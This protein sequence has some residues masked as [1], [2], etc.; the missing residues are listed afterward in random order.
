MTKHNM[1][2]SE[3]KEKSTLYIMT[4]HN[5]QFSENKEKST[6]YIMTK[7]NMQFS[8]NKEKSTLYIMTKHNMQFSENKEKSKL[9]IMTKQHAIFRRRK[10]IK[11]MYAIYYDKTER[12]RL[13]TNACGKERKNR[14]QMPV[15]KKERTGHKCLRQRKKD[16]ENWH[17]VF[18]HNKSTAFLLTFS[19]VWIL[20]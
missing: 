17:S 13:Y 3:N 6:L 5:M 16:P 12:K 15:A 2:F 14:P 4:K 8:E 19:C 9:Y 10:K 18:C 7:H 20:F 11:K 1:Q